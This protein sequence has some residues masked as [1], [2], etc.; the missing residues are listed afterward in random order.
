MYPHRLAFFH[1]PYSVFRLQCIRHIPRLSFSLPSQHQCIRRQSSSLTSRVFPP[2]VLRRRDKKVRKTRP[3]PLNPSP[4]PP[5][6]R[7]R[8]IIWYALAFI[9]SGC[10][11]YTA[12][13][14][15]NSVTHTFHGVIRCS[16]V[17]VALAHCVY[18]YRMAMRRKHDTE[19][20]ATQDMSDCHLRC[21]QRALRVF[22]KNGGIY[23]KIGQ[24]LAAL[25]YLI[26]I[27]GSPL[28]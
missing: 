19:E 13:H 9:A 18:D 23:I 20:E 24:H 28:P 7:R 10:I 14:P 15:D 2:P 16:R 21:A 5:F 1:P 11:T 6:R 4:T 17:T 3:L 27:V 12:L 26:P 25:S 22:E 8:R